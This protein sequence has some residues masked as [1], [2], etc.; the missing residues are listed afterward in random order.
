MHTASILLAI[1]E[2]ITKL[3]EAK[4]ILAGVNTPATRKPGRP[5]KVVSATL[6]SPVETAAKS[7]ARP[8]MSAEGRA[9]IAAAQKARWAKARKTIGIFH[10]Q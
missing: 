8:A 2:Q 7:E 5:P 1:D 9:K 10:R 3:Q 6:A 4:A